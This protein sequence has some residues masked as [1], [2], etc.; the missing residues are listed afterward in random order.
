MEAVYRCPVC[1]KV[2]YSE[3]FSC[4]SGEKGG[5]AGRGESKRRDSEKMRVA[6]L[7]R[8]HRKNSD[9]PSS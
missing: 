8:W 1:G 6:A 2:V 4:K 7:I 3:H 5:K 9:K